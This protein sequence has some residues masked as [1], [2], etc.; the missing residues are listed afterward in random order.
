V[1]LR[2]LRRSNDQALHL[3]SLSQFQDSDRA[4]GAWTHP[5]LSLPGTSYA[6]ILLLL[7]VVLMLHACRRRNTPG[8]AKAAFAQVYAAAS[9]SE[10]GNMRGATGSGER[11]GLSHRTCA[12]ADGTKPTPGVLT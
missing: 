8:L 6:A 4:A 10:A 12:S 9:S 7:T 1:V 3:V 11:I 5:E 2:L